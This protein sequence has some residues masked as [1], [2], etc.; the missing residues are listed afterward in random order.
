[1]TSNLA[2]EWQCP[3]FRS[4]NVS[5]SASSTEFRIKRGEADL[6]GLAVDGGTGIAI[7]PF[8][9]PREDGFAG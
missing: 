9:H 4:K 3:F 2:T 5:A 7:M 6:C 8:G 1:M